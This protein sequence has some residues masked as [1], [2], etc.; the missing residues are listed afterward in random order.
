MS[1]KIWMSYSQKDENDTRDSG[2]AIQK[3]TVALAKKS[4]PVRSG[5]LLSI[6]PSI[7]D[8]IA[9]NHFSNKD[10]VVLDFTNIIEQ[11]ETILNFIRSS[12]VSIMDSYEHKVNDDECFRVLISLKTI[13]K[14]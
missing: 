3:Y 10:V 12:G 1:E 2:R 7:N 11:H 9:N 8:G 6:M 4:L 5:Y 13:P 14:N